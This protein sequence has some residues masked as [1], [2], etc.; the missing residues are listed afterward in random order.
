MFDKLSQ[1]WRRLLFYFRR[2]QFD[3]ELEE[4]MR[5]HLEMKAEENLAASVSPEE[6][7]YAAQ[8][9]F[10]NQTLL[11][12]E[13]RDMWAVRSIDTLC[14]DLRYGIRLLIKHKGFTTVAALS[15]ALG[16]GANT[17]IFSLINAASLRMLPVP[18]P[19]RLV[20]L[21]VAGQRGEAGSFSYPLY[22]QF[23]DR[24]KSFSGIL[25]SGGGN[26][27]RMVVSEPG[28][29]GQ[30]ESVQTERVSGNFFSVLGVTAIRG[31]TLTDDDDRPGAP[32]PVAVIS[33]GFWQRRFGLDPAV[34]G[35]NIALND[36]PFT[37]IGVTP[38][39]F[40]GFEV[41]KNPDLWWPLQ[42]TPQVYPAN[43]SWNQ[44]GS[45]WLR[46][47]GRLRPDRGQ[48]QAMAELDF[49]FQQALAERAQAQAARLGSTWTETERRNFLDRRIALRSGSAGWTELRQQ[50]RQ[51]LLI[52][53]AVVGLVLLIACANVANLLLARAAARQK[54][55]TARLAL[56]ASRLRLVRQLLTES[57]L[58]A[59][60]GGALGLIF[61]YW[62]ARLLLSYLPGHETLSLNL[63]LDARVLGFT[64]TV[65]LLTGILFGLAPA[66][67]A[68]RL[69]LTSALKDQTGGARIGQ[70]RLPLNKILVVT[71][72]ALSLFLLI[73]AGL[74]VRSLQKLRGLDL[75]FDRENVV[76]FSLDLGTGY[77]AARA[78]NLFRRLL[79]RLETLPGTRSASLSSYGLL[80][81]N[82]WGDKVIAQGYT[83]RPDEDLTCHGQIIGPRFF[84]TMG[85]PLLL[86]R[87]FSSQDDQLRR[88]AIINQAM[89]R[90]FFPNENPIG[91]R[92]SIIGQTDQPIEIVGVVKDAKYQTLRE[93]APRTFYLPFF[94]Q[95]GASDTT[96]E[97]RTFIQP[98]GLAES[99]RR[100]A[101]ELDPKLQ[102]IGLRKMND[103]VDSALTQ[104]RFVAQLAGFFSLF[105]LLLAAIGLYGVMSYT[106][107]HRI[108]EI[109]IRMA[110]GAQ[111]VDVI[112]L[113]MRETAL[114]VGIGVIIGLGA[115]L[116]FTRLISSLLF[117][118]T[119]TDPLTI[120]LASLL[121]IASA[122]LAGFLPARRACRVDPMI[123][124]RYE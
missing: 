14:Q 45:S 75:G 76:L 66:L 67:R 87:D 117:D 2:D 12:E 93:R 103:V 59:M 69:D 7:R 121:M 102:I 26:R 108:S 97:L 104:E 50:F 68:T 17:A 88:V 42:M 118:L 53:L 16:I 25:A 6:A 62:S 49:I 122:A 79:E 110:L 13:S 44:P 56:G 124:L 37:I 94:Q 29:A 11:W 8:R 30:N 5:F 105:A 22:E 92:F 9:Q 80:S 43:Q 109:G 83:P 113:V 90:D 57:A 15:L 81:N 35:K 96:F 40:F 58:L 19:E 115:A 82:Y 112:K 86:G 20:V 54:E 73:G 120:A 55:I 85:I 74:F 4:E 31:R 70:S 24:T 107:S 101:L 72:V 123:A 60:I 78:T 61:A 36:V 23:R 1:L 28:G 63:D 47:M 32:R 84:E 48:A 111:A 91:K 46:L 119:P 116:A 100:V 71:Q 39:G 52:L 27:S 34:V 21:A 33:Y 10:G 77:D 89:A 106:V 98:A 41:G 3:R 64:M 18:N 38:P 65:S 95:L 51:P 114:L 99:I